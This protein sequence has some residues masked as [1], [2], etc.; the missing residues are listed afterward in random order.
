MYKHTHINIVCL[1]YLCLSLPLPLPPFSHTRTDSGV[2]A[3]IDS[4]YEYCLKSYVVLGEETYLKRFA[5][6]QYM[7]TYCM[8]MC[9]N[10]QLKLQQTWQE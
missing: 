5:K 9:M 7:H 6:V 1:C 2:G 8:Y 10:T 4:Y 3:G